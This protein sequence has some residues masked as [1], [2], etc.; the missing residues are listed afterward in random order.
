MNPKNI[1]TI[2]LSVWE[3]GFV[4]AVQH[5]I[6]TLNITNMI[7]VMTIPIPGFT[8]NGLGCPQCGQELANGDTLP[9]HAEQS[10]SSIF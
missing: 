9:L 4:T 10:T 6:K 3:L 2:M 5:A 1:L 7:I 8:A